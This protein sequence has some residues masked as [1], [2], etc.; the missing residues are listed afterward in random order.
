[1]DLDEELTADGD[2]QPAAPEQTGSVWGWGILGVSVA[3]L[4]VVL[5][6]RSRK[7]DR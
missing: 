3:A 6:V 2:A 4:A 1:M 7:K 5:V